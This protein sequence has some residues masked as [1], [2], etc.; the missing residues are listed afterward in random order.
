MKLPEILSP[1]AETKLPKVQKA[2]AATPKRRRMANVLDV[3]ETVKTLSSTPRKIAKALKAQTEVETKPTKI[4]AAKFIDEIF[5]KRRAY[6]R[7]QYFHV[8]YDNQKKSEIDKM[9]WLRSENI[10]TDKEFFVVLEEIEA[11]LEN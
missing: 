8:D 3:L 11:N 7:D 4:E 5:T 2:P 6:Y 10:I 1:P 9:K